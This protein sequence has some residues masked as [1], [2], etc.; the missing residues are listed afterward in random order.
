MPFTEYSAGDSVAGH[1]LEIRAPNCGRRPFVSYIYGTCHATSETGCSTPVQVQTW[2]ACHRKPSRAPAG[3]DIEVRRG[4]TTVIVFAH[5]DRL[6][7]TAARALRRA[8]PPDAKRSAI[9]KLRA[10]GGR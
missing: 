5:S 10:C 8:R 2:S 7:R 6:A 4:E 1:E 9:R 3:H